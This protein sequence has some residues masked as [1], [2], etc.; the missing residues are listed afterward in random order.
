MA[1]AHRFDFKFPR[2]RGNDGVLVK[3]LPVPMV[4]LVATAVSAIST[5]TQGY[6][7]LKFQLFAAI[8]EWSTGTYGLIYFTADKYSDVYNGHIGTLSNIMAQRPG[9]FHIMMAELYSLARCVCW[10]DHYDHR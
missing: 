6:T 10:L 3:E 1:Y 9:A 8:H 4:A 5:H 7:N 2:S